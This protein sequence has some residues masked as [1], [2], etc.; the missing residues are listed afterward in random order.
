MAEISP[1]HTDE[2]YTP[3]GRVGKANE[4]AIAAL[5]SILLDTGQPVQDKM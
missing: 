1:F 2:I 3:I 4:T 5:L